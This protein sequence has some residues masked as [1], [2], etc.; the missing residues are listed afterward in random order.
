MKPVIRLAKIQ[1]KCHSIENIVINI[2]F[3]MIKCYLFENI[4]FVIVLLKTIN[5]NVQ[6]KNLD[7]ISYFGSGFCLNSKGKIK[8]S[9][10]P[11]TE[12]Y[13]R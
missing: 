5:K 3:F 1:K 12:V 2:V 13:F 6:I 10:S 7:C 4:G 8:V 11:F 9:H